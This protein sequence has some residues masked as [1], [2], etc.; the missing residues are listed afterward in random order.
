[1]DSLAILDP[2]L[3]IDISKL[4]RALPPPAARSSRKEILWTSDMVGSLL[5]HLR[6]NFCIFSNRD[7]ARGEPSLIELKHA[8]LDFSKQ[9]IVIPSLYAVFRFIGSLVDFDIL[10][11]ETMLFSNL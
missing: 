9:S 1:M 8:R 2:L 6:I 5:Y 10:P 11:S 3:R 4:E 7:E